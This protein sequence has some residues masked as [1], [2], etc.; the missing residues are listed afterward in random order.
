MKFLSL[1]TK[2]GIDLGSGQIRICNNSGEVV[3]NEASC[4]AIDNNNQKVLAVG[5]KAL[6]MKERVGANIEVHH[7]IQSGVI[8][9]S[10]VLSAL[11]K[12]LFSRVLSNYQLLRPTVIVSI[13]A[14]AHRVEQEA[15][16]EVLHELG[17][18]EVI[19]VVSPLAAGIGSGVPIAQAAG[20]CVLHMGRGL[21]EA[22][23][24]SLGS[25]LITKQSEYAGQYMDEQIQHQVDKIYSLKIGLETAEEIKKS[26]LS[27][28][29][30]KAPIFISGK[31]NIDNSP[32]ELEIEAD[33]F[34][35]LIHAL[36]NRYIKLLELVLQEA[37]PEL[38]SDIIDRGVLLTG[39]F[40]QLEGL[41]EYL[42]QELGI[43]MLD[44]E[45][46]ELVVIKGIASILEHLDLF[47]ESVGYQ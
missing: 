46:P 41:R 32:Q 22:S 17:A 13:P 38:S 23:I 24:M 7:P 28:K 39:A 42:A 33:K 35:P 26:F 2:I 3:V 37:P 19:I 43:A 44:V 47:K 40:S 34:S 11:L 6:E 25:L 14:S 18:G 31:A 10:Q 15:V 9:D 4:I 27:L 45:D 1:D 30:K 21:V 20:S 8:I 5:F 36:A 12:V 16:I 29:S